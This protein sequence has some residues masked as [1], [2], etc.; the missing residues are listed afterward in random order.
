MSQNEISKSKQKRLDMEKARKEQRRKK[1]TAIFLGIMIPVAIVAAIIFV[2]L[3]YQGS[4]LSYGKYLTEEGLISGIDINSS[5]QYDYKSLSFN[6]VDLL[7]SEDTIE[8]DI[9]S[10]CET[11]AELSTEPELSCVSENRINMS[12]TANIGTVSYN[13]VTEQDYVIG[14]GTVS[15]MFDEALIGHAPGDQFVTGITYPEDYY[16]TELAGAT[17]SYDIT[18]HGIYVVPEFT[19]ELVAENFSYIATTVEDYRSYLIEEYFRTNLRE[20][21]KNSLTNDSIVLVTPEKYSENLEAL[22]H[23]QYREQFNYYNDMFMNSLGY[24]AYT[25]P[26]QM[27]GYSTEEEYNNY[28]HSITES[29]V[30]F[31]LA[32][33]YIYTNEG[34]T[35]SKDEVLAY[36]YS[37]GY[38]ETSFNELVAQYDYRYLAQM[39]L[40][41]K[42]ITYL[43]DT[44]TINE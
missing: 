4:R 36:Y 8:G 11:L 28:I 31:S 10:T 37:Q 39:A 9:Q 6:R 26:Y 42:V 22:Y 29:D 14:S 1:N 13:E 5:V 30:A 41:D 12:Y 2:Y 21:I 34:M 33:M 38:D 3:L 16:D 35:N 32:I 17:V 23:Y 40:A 15:T 19:D 20:A 44:V 27:F 24:N 18:I 25:E 43:A 7:P